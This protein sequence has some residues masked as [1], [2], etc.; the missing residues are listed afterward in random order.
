MTDCSS[1]PHKVG[2]AIEGVFTILNPDT[3][4]PFD[5]PG[6]VFAFSHSIQTGVTTSLSVTRVVQGTYK[7]SFTPTTPGPWVLRMCDAASGLPTDTTIF[8]EQRFNVRPADY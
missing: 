6:G 7:A 8:E 1:T 3:G 2:Q 4:Q 5:P